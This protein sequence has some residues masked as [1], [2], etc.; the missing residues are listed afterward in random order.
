MNMTID[1]AWLD[2]FEDDIVRLSRREPSITG[3]AM[4]LVPE[5]LTGA[6][7]I[8]A[9]DPEGARIGALFEQVVA[10]MVAR[11]G[12]LSGP[13]I[14]QILEVL[15]DRHFLDRPLSLLDGGDAE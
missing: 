10:A 4:Y 8:F 7:A 12:P 15:A 9:P 2:A 14:S 1:D 6:P 13:D 3:V 5:D 11:N